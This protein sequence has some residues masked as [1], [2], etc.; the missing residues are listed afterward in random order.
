MDALDYEKL[1]NQLIR[2]EGDRLDRERLTVL[3]ED[4]RAVAHEL[5]A[6]WPTLG[7]VDAIR[8]RVLIHMTF[9]MGIRG[10]LAM[11]R[12]AS[13]VEFRLW[14]TAA[15][16]MLISQWAKQEPRR[17]NVLAAMIRTGRDD[18]LRVIQPEAHNQQQVQPRIRT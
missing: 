9:N 6:S 10:L 3:E 7:D 12:F 4:V 16:E 18:V 17:A 1:L 11:L 13:A 8:K 14:D 2:L 5:E 15:D